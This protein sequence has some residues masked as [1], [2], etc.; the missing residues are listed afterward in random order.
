[1]IRPGDQVPPPRQTAPGSGTKSAFPFAPALADNPIFLVV[2]GADPLSGEEK[3]LLSVLVQ[4]C[5]AVIAKLELLAAE[6]ANIER[7]DRLNADLASTVSTLPKI[8]ETHR[9][10]NK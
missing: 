5:G 8:M 7:A 1:M 6:R 3:F 10:L 9:Q 2:A 4:L